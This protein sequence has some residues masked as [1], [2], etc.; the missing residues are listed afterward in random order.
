MESTDPIG[1]AS[2]IIFLESAYT[3]PENVIAI[4]SE[5]KRIRHGLREKGASEKVIDALQD[6]DGITR[7]S[8]R[9][10]SENRKLR[11]RI[12]ISPSEHFSLESIN[13]R[14]QSYDTAKLPDIQAL[15]D[16]MV[17]LCMRPAEV[18]TLR[19]S[20][21]EPP[22]DDALHRGSKASSQGLISDSLPEWW[23]PGCNWYATT[24][25]H[26]PDGPHSPA[27]NY[28]IINNRQKILPSEPKDK[29][30]TPY[31]DLIEELD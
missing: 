10:Q 11:A 27:E 30:D 2:T 18:T 12:G 3:T 26:S 24:L 4:D 7:E 14:L 19:I 13:A 21:F 28:A 15:A 17:M 22:N 25:R 20:Y 5:L 1:E 23:V 8:N 29:V 16:V 31:N 9:K 6:T